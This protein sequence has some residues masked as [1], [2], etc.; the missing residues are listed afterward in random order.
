MSE[1]K[2]IDVTK[3]IGNPFTMYDKGWAEICAAKAD[4]SVNAMTASWGA[5]GTIWNKPTVTVYIRQT[6]F[7]K[8]F[9]D[10]TG[11]FSVNFLNPKNFR[12]T[13][14]YLGKVSGRDEDKIAKSGLNIIK[15][16]DLPYFA[17]S[18]LVMLCKTLCRQD[19]T[20]E[21][22]NEDIVG[23]WYDNDSIHT[24]YIAEVTGLMIR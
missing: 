12:E 24:M 4:G 10:E 7:T 20:L 6:R 21:S 2:K 23:Q 9:V 1:L 18:S 14:Q 13:Q 17:E 8:E 19:I 3:F 16:N 22:L 15:E 5:V 11:R